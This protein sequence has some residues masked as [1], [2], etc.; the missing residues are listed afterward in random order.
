MSTLTPPAQ[1]L[2]PPFPIRPFTVDEYHR[3]IEL[4]FFTED[5]PVELLEGW[6][7]P[8]MPGNPPHDGTLDRAADALAGRLA[9]AQSK[10]HHADG[11]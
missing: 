8:K 6:I 1:A 10:G 7:T 2:I 9:R 3:M 11:Q 5:D 4:G